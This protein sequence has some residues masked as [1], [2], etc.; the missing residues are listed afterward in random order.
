VKT[1]EI[2]KIGSVT[3]PL[4]L[5]RRITTVGSSGFPVAGDVVAYPLDTTADMID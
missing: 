4:G 3:S 1:V 5:G 2:D